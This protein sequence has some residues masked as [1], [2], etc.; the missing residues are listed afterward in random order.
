MKETKRGC[1]EYKNELGGV[2]CMSG[3]TIGQRV[4]YRR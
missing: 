4:A 2:R 3:V 1:D